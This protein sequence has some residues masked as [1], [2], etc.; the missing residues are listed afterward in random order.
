MRVLHCCLAA[1]YIDDYGYQENILPKMHRLLGHEVAIIASTET[2]VKKSELSYVDPASYETM[3]GIPITRIPYKKLIPSFLAPKLRLYENLSYHLK[4]FDPDIIFLHDCQFLSIKEVVDY[5]NGHPGVKVYVDGHTD[6]I[7][8][9]RNWFSKYILH[10]I[11]YKWCAKKIERYAL[12]F[13]GV[14]PARVEFFT[15]MY[16]IPKTKVDLLVCGADDT[17]LDFERKPGIR[18]D[19]RKRVGINL[20]DFVV[21][22]GGKID[23]R[24]NIHKLMMAV[25]EINNRKIKLIVFGVP[26]K[27]MEPIIKS[28]SVHANI[29]SVGW[30]SS[31]KV[32]DYLFAADLGFFPG[33]H[34]VLWEQAVGSG[35]PCV[36]KKYM[37][38][39]LLKP[40]K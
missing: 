30:I 22:T 26:N 31:D 4:A 27:D 32:Y 10:G 34:S 17:L 14:L 19:V 2:Y 23:R 18:I 33:T 6:F 37:V 38:Y 5:L 12:K 8:S 1:F 9:A 28:L 35:V 24:K 39:Y 36:F 15:V 29:K 40:Q 7:N 25:S 21:I 3:D 11:I 16:G 20:D 13:Y